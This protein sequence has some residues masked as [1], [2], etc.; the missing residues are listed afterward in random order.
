MTWPLAIGMASNLRPCLGTAVEKAHN[1]NSTRTGCGRPASGALE[2]LVFP[3]GCDIKVAGPEAPPPPPAA[4][5]TPLP[6]GA[7]VQV[8][9]VALPVRGSWS[10]GWLS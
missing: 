9:G 3:I 2:P 7:G 8:L 1:M 5:P 4:A 10:R 6:P